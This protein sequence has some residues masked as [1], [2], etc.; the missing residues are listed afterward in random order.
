[1]PSPHTAPGDLW[2]KNLLRPD[3]TLSPRVAD[4]DLERRF[5]RERTQGD[6][7]PLD[8]YSGA[9]YQT[10]KDLARA[11]GVSSVLEVGPGW[12]NYTFRLLRDFS[13]VT[14]V[15]LSPDNLTYLNRR[16][17][18]TG[19]TLE[20]ICAPWEAAEA[21][22][23]DM[24]F[25]YNCFYRVRE[26]ELFL[27]KLHRTARRLCVAGMNEP[28]ELPWI[29]ALEAAGLS[30][31]YTR[32]GCRE[33]GGILDSIGIPYQLLNIPNHREYRYP[34]QEALLA[35]V[36]GFLLEEVPAQR[37]LSIVMPFHRELPGGS[38]V[39]R[40][41]FNSQLLVWEPA[42]SGKSPL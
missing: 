8:P 6:P 27:D 20:T 7:I 18:E 10:V 5:W 4:L 21:P 14:C 37:L 23:R 24:A 11:H 9:V 41:L 30:I 35:R 17:A 1:M 40:Y 13:R 16:A 36:R 15:D 33:L 29:P 2:R 22:P 38:L 19:H 31:H 3:G 26:P 42:L 12:G 34:N 28:P 32:Q 39:C 25:A